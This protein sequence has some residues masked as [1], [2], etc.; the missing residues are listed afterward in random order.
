MADYGE[1]VD[2]TKKGSGFFGPLKTP[3]GQVMTELSFGFN[4]GNKEYLAPL[5]TPNLSRAE[6]DHLVSGGKPSEAIYD[7]AI[8]H[9]MERLRAGKDMFAGPNEQVP[10][11][12]YSLGDLLY[13]P[14]R[15]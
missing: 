8:S 13:D 3:D 7:K 14:L 15:K 4:M 9:A 11:P 6:I 2:K 10:L 1:R 12:S 5:L